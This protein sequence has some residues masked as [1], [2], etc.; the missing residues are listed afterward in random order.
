ME[1]ILNENRL[2][3]FA[4]DFFSPPFLSVTLTD[5]AF[6]TQAL[7]LS[8]RVLRRVCPLP[9][10]LP[11]LTK[12]RLGSIFFGYD[13]GVISSVLPAPNF[14]EVTGHPDDNYQG[15]IVSALLLG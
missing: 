7:H 1:T 3:V 15:F 11:S 6:V 2:S 5:H 12:F 14:L 8:L 13:L 4:A 9:L 10:P